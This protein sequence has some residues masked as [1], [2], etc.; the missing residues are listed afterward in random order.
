MFARDKKRLKEVTHTNTCAAALPH[1][2]FKI[3]GA[4]WQPT[5]KHV[6]NLQGKE[7]KGK[8]RQGKARNEANAAYKLTP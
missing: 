4:N 6:H 2:P 5:S 7:S 3:D 1:L 8:G